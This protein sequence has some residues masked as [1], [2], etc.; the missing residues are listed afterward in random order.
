LL[1]VLLYICDKGKTHGVKT[2]MNDAVWTMVREIEDRQKKMSLD[3]LQ[4]L[5]V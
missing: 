3:N 1:A 5:L 4:E 2:P